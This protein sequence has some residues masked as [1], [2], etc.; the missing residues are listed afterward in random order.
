[1]A[2]VVYDGVGRT[3]FDTSL[4][5]LRTRGTMVSIGATSG[6]PHPV[7]IRRINKTS[8]FLT[9]PSLVAYASDPDEYAARASDLFDAI[10]DGIIAP[11]IWRSF[12][13]DQAAEVHRLLEAGET[14]G[15]VLLKP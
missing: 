2:D 7:D 4:D 1:M 6:I 8:L 5:C 10:R 14:K 13:L 12:P 11:D 9:R 3:T 15:A